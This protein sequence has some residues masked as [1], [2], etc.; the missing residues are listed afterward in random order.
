VRS[1]KRVSAVCVATLPAALVLAGCVSTQR[2]AARARLVS[3]RILASQSA[4]GVVSP[5][6]DV[7]V[8]RLTLIRAR[9]GTAIVVPLRN[10]T[11]TTL[12]DLPIS[13]AIRT[14]H[15]ELYLN[16]SANLDYFQ[17]HVPAIGPHDW[18]DWVFTTGRRVAG[19]RAVATVG[20]A[21]IHP[22]VAGGL[23]RLEVS[24]HRTAGVTVS[25]R[26][27]I[28][29]YDLP[30]YVVAVRAGRVVSAGQA[31][32][33]HLGT[34]ATTSISVTLLGDANGAALRLIASPT[35]LS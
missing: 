14:G 22:P 30:V 29:Q 27:T 21:Q 35:I 26:S 28:P 5:N 8:G 20:Y 17:T 16:R 18:T 3:A 6:P 19:G 23:P 9:T 10:N 15:R 7:S 11:S 25:N 24:A 32:I 1:V 31:E 34:H 2:I 12:T 4:T 13:L 33:A